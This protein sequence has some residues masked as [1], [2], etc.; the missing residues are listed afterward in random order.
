FHNADG[1]WANGDGILVYPGTQ[2]AA[3]VGGPG[4]AHAEARVDYGVATVFPSVRLKNLRRG[5]EDAGYIALARAV[6]R[7]EADAIVR[8][9][10]PRALA[11]ADARAS[12]PERGGAWLEARRDL[13]RI[14]EGD[15]AH[16]SARDARGV[17]GV[18]GADEASAT[19]DVRAPVA[20]SDGC[21]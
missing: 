3:V 9:V 7:A 14:I 10:V 17:R 8:R 11:L 6:D 21:S 18:P 4:Q 19:S 1:D 13:A 15:I 2:R 16:A 5:I 12:W 20:M